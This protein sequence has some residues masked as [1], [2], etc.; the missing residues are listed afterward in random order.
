MRIQNISAI[1]L[2]Y[3][4]VGILLGRYLTGVAI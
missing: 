3:K 1:G 4:N 2:N